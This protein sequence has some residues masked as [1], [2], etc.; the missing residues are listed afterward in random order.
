MAK[1]NKDFN[2]DIFNDVDER[3]IDE[4]NKIISEFT[5]NGTS[6]HISDVD[7]LIEQIEKKFENS[8]VKVVVKRNEEIF[9]EFKETPKAVDPSKDKRYS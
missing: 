9:E 5:E 1:D 8:G 2:D 3:V 4:I 6:V 7:E